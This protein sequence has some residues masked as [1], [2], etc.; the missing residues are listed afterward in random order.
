MPSRLKHCSQW[1][2]TEDEV[3]QAKA[4]Q[5]LGMYLNVKPQDMSTNQSFLYRFTLAEWRKYSAMSHGGCEGYIGELPAGGYFVQ[6]TLPMEQR[7]QIERAYTIFL[8]RH[9]GRAALILLRIVTDL[10][11]YFRFDGADINARIMKI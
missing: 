4:W 11:L 8:T 3:R 5:T 7:E 2:F 1:C 10:Q 9:I 6:D